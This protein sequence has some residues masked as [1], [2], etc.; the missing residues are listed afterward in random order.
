M[1]PKKPRKTQFISDTV[2]IVAF[3]CCNRFIAVLPPPR[4]RGRTQ[5][6]GAAGQ[7]LARIGW[8]PPGADGRRTNYV[9]REGGGE[10]G[11][12]GREVAVH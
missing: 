2:K 1:D 5:R 12:I 4:F 9:T 7:A 8:L 3:E 10:G 6:V 11:Q